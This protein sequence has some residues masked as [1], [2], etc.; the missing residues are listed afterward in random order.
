MYLTRKEN[1]QMSAKSNAKAAKA[2]KPVQEV[3][4]AAEKTQEVYVQFN[5]KEVNMKAVLDRVEEIWTKDME[6]KA[7]DMKEVKVYL[8]IEDNAAYFVINGDIT[9]SFGL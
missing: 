5:D 3:K 2:V 4:K 9:G 7:E 6:N 1:R 8:K